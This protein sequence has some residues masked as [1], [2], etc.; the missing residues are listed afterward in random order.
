MCY[1]TCLH[2]TIHSIFDYE[3]YVFINFLGVKVILV[4]Y[5]LENEFHCYIVIFGHL[6]WI[7]QV[8]VLDIYNQVSSVWG[9][10]EAIPME[11]GRG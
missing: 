2:H 3:V 6:Y 11:F 10:Y 7:V 4:Y 1:D 9:E 5:L 8:E